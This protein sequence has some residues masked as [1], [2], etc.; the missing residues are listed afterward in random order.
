MEGAHERRKRLRFPLRCRVLFFRKS[1]DAIADAVTQNVSS[2]G[3]YCLSLNP[4]SVGESLT[5][6]LM[7]PSYGVARD[8]SFR[9]ECV[10][11][12]V[13]ME[14][15]NEEGLFGIGCQIDD[16]HAPWTEQ[17]S[18]VQFGKPP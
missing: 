6:L 15:A 5:C 7:M 1:S 8:Q 12:V 4:L 2:A 13:R 18:G 9:V 3:F 10:V 11:R 14:K 17:P 16:Y